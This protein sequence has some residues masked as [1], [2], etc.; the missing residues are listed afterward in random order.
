MLPHSVSDY[1]LKASTD[2]DTTS[3]LRALFENFAHWCERGLQILPLPLLSA[4][5]KSVRA[6]NFSMSTQLK[7]AI[8]SDLFDDITNFKTTYGHMKAL[9]NS[10]VLVS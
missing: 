7:M 6:L 2:L 1:L 5:V 4:T 3:L 9:Y 8:L 10:K